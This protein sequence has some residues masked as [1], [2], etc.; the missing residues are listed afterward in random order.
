VTSVEWVT[1][2]GL[3]IVYRRAGAGPVLL[4][5]DCGFSY[6]REWATQL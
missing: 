4:L 1:V 2:G 3:R 5:L 6:H